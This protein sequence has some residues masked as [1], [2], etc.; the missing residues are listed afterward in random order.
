MTGTT[1]KTIG[2]C[3]VKTPFMKGGAEILCKELVLNLEARG[4]CADL[5]EVPFNPWPVNSLLSN[6]AAWRL[7]EP[8]APDGKPIDLLITTKFPSFAIKHDNKVAWVFHQM[9]ELFDSNV[10]EGYFAGGF[11][12]EAVRRQLIGL[13]KTFLCE[14]K[15]LFTIS[16]NVAN[17]LNKYHGM[18]AKTLYPPPKLIGRYKNNGYGDYILSVGRLDPWKRTELLIKA[19]SKCTSKARCVIIGSGSAESELHTLAEKSGLSER[20]EFIRFVDDEKLI[21]LYA[22]A[23][24]VFFGPRDEDYGFITIEAFLSGKPVITC[25]DSGGPLE[26]VING[27]N[28]FVVDSDP[29]Q[30]ASAIDSL[31]SDSESAERMGKHGYESLPAFS[32]D[33]IIENL[34]VPFL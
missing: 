21:D 14:H 1:K 16:S 9:R 7:L 17:R 27:K 2:V 10:A 26:F 34:V 8:T 23:R 12:D 6:A 20:V 31:F 33:E 18:E 24:G 3:A 19:L 15:D 11:S 5:L 4:Y 29:L 28:G 13:D 22:G 30:I 32:W 25:K